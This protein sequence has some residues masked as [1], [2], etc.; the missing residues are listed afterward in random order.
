ALVRLEVAAH[1]RAEAVGLI[2]E[3]LVRE[4]D[5]TAEPG[6]ARWARQRR[7]GGNGAGPRRRETRD[8]VRSPP[9]QQP[10]SRSH[11]R[12]EDDGVEKGRLD[13]DLGRTTEGEGHGT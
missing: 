7:E 9:C 1:G 8:A 4:R 12:A 10:P 2:D 5:G 6:V 3:R 13:P 11:D